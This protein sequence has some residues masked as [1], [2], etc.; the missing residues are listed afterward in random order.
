MF[1][2]ERNHIV[3]VSWDRTIKVWKS[4]RRQNLTRQ[5]MEKHKEKKFETWVWDAMKLAL[6]NPK[7]NSDLT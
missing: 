1:I 2:P 6:K 3:T 4:Y 7:N 5:K